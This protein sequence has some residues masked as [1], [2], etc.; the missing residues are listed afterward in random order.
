MAFEDEMGRLLFNRNRLY[1]H[2]K[3]AQYLRVSLLKI[4]RDRLVIN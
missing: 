1:D 2:F 4:A 3:L